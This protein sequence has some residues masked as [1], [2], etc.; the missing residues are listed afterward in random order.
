MASK[1]LRNRAQRIA[2]AQARPARQA[3]HQQIQ[4]TRHDTHQQVQSLSSMGA[5]VQNAIDAA[6]HDFKSIPGLK[7]SDQRIALEQLASLGA[8]TAAGIASSKAEARQTGREAIVGLRQTM[9][10]ADVA[11]VL[12]NLLSQRA[13]NRHDVKMTKLTHRLD[14]QS[15]LAQAA[16]TA[17]ADKKT[18]GLTPNELRGVRQDKSSAVSLARSA[19]QD[20]TKA[21]RKAGHALPSPSAWSDER[22]KHYA[23]SLVTAFPTHMTGNL[24]NYAV[25]RLKRSFWQ[26]S[27]G[28]FV[29]P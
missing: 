21:A 15:A 8:Q 17:K 10:Q 1:R 9:P 24:A 26:P 4:A 19:L 28:V 7:G 5:G 13:S 11:S 23:D 12:A 22:W 3:Q 16:A 20:Y 2:Q 14:L 18:G 27:R 6:R 25:R 29:A